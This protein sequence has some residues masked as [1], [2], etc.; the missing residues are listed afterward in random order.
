MTSAALSLLVALTATSQVTYT[1]RVP[2]EYQ[3]VAV[4]NI[5]QKE[6]D[7]HRAAYK[8]LWEQDL[9]TRF[10]D[11]PASG[12]VPDYRIPYSGHDYPDRTGG[13][14]AAMAKYD[15]AFHR[16][17]SRAYQ[18][19]REDLAFHA[20]VKK[21]GR[22]VVHRGR[23][24]RVIMVSHAEVVPTWYGHCNGWTAAAIRHAEPQKSVV[25][26]G[27]T[28]TPADIKGMLAEIYMYSPTQF[29]GGVDDAINPAVLH[30]ALANWIGRQK[31]PIGMETSVGDPVVNFPIF[32]YRTG[33]RRL[34]ANRLD[35]R[36]IITYALH[37]PREYDKSPKSTREL[38]FHYILDLDRQGEIIGGQYYGDS[39]RIDMVWTPLKPV[40]GGKEGNESG[41]PHLDLE[42]VLAI[43]RESVDPEILKQWVNIDPTD[44]ERALAKKDLP[45][46]PTEPSGEQPA[47]QDPAAAPATTDAVST[48]APAS[49]ETASAPMAVPS[50]MVVPA[51]ATPTPMPM[52]TTP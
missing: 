20:T 7:D 48:P 18:H 32:A 43:H 40:Q 37:V 31:H 2:V 4:S 5:Q 12:K 24:G 8:Q 6:L 16:G 13:T 11:L 50:P 21:P 39:G 23:F 27:I 30:I 35:V 42:E 46:K 1:Y 22:E 3:S 36:T 38:Y 25:R 15:R 10:D 33:V 34:S 14:L 28:F 47:D 52:A 26:N 51:A 41:N 45:V 44:A 9:I 49:T 17:V 19:E 29:L